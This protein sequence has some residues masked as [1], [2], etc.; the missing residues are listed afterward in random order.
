[1]KNTEYIELTELWQDGEYNKVSDII[2]SEQ[3]SP[4]RVAEFCSYFNKFLGSSQLN[5]LH[6]FLQ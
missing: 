3:W 6:K 4:A 1:M 2:N 5:I